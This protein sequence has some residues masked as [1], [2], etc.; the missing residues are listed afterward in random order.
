MVTPT[1]GVCALEE[2]KRRMFEHSEVAVKGER[3]LEKRK[4]KKNHAEVGWEEKNVKNPFIIK[5]GY[6]TPSKNIN[7]LRIRSRLYLE[8]FVKRHNLPTIRHPDPMRIKIFMER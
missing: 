6:R 8:R 2:V 1:Q 4:A 5:D 7:R 3:S